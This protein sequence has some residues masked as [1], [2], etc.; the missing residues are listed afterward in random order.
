MTEGIW[1]SSWELGSDFIPKDRYL[2]RAFLELELEKLW[3]RV[4]QVAC[5]EEQIP[6][7]GSYCEYEIGDQPLLIVRGEGGEIRAF[8]NACRHRGR[9]LASGCGRFEGGTIRCPYH[10]WVWKL[11]G[12]NSHVYMREEFSPE[13]LS[14]ESLRLREC[15]VA[16]WAGFVFINMDPA[17]PPLETFIA[18]ATR[19]LDPVAIDRMGVLWHKVT[20]LPIN[21]K[22]AFDAFHESYHV[23]STH[24]E[25][26]ALG[27]D[28]NLF[29][30][31]MDPGGHHH[32]AIPPT[33]DNTPPPG[34]DPREQ[35]RDFIAYNVKEIGGMYTERDVQVATQLMERE[36]PE[37]SSV[38]GAFAAALL[39]H[40]EETAAPLPSPSVE[41]FAHT[42]INF[43]F[44]HLMLLPT[45]G[46]ALCYRGRPNGLDP[47][48]TIWD[49]W[50][51]T[52]FPE[53]E[54][55]PPYETQR[56]DWRDEKQVGRVLFQDFSNL[57]ECARG[58][59]SHSF[60]GMRLNN[61]QEMALLHVQQ[62]IDKYLRS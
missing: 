34:V 62:E 7:V 44:P 54:R 53:G 51:L 42:G 24:P 21:W 13:A 3:P 23:R 25:Y 61:A 22:A 48:S 31:Q 4:W 55:P 8:H 20:V 10:G 56:V 26:H 40:A 36:I 35:L 9:R 18:P 1:S 11:D 58:I 5:R 52:I 28:A 14:E 27:T 17:A 29:R 43:I 60:E 57:Y 15:Q 45:L 19:W 38:A 16:S 6:E 32:Y 49:V 41:D 59:R 47:E 37:G 39:A 46:N 50:S 30:Y 2:S 33:S 12:R